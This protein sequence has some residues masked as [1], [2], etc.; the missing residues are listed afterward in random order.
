[1]LVSRRGWNGE[2]RAPGVADSG[3]GIPNSGLWIPDSGGENARA[4]LGGGALAVLS[5]T[6]RLDSR[7]TSQFGTLWPRRRRLWPTRRSERGE[8]SSVAVGRLAAGRR[9][10][11]AA[12]PGLW[13][14]DSGTDLAVLDAERGIGT[15]LWCFRPIPDSGFRIPDSEFRNPESGSGTPG[16][17]SGRD[18]HFG[19]TARKLSAPYRELIHPEPIPVVRFGIQAF[20]CPL[21]LRVEDSGLRTQRQSTQG[22]NCHHPSFAGACGRSRS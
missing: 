6:P 10:R 3:F 22:S 2:E 9:R 14:P 1:M 19:T 5:E 7:L 11:A 20:N 12:D 13:I 17:D 21:A 4:S 15:M 18:S 16:T 8:V